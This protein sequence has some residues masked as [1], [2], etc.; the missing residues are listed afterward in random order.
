MRTAGH[1]GRGGTHDGR[2]AVSWSEESPTGTLSDVGGVVTYRLRIDLRRRWRRALGLTLLVAVLGG[3]VLATTAGA[4]R[5]SSAYDR[6][7]DADQPSRAAGLAAW[8]RHRRD[9][10]LRRGGGGSTVCAASGSLP[11]SHWSPSA[12]RRQS[13][14][15]NRSPADRRAGA[16]RQHARLGH[17]PTARGRRTIARPGSADEILVSKRFAEHDDV[18]VG[19]LI[20]AVVLTSRLR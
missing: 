12:G 2:E 17:R 11:A 8:R 5:T 3:I 16:V 9:S 10:V 15:A 6:L 18:H 14:W 4:R 1:R 19:D 7:L 13:G 20:D